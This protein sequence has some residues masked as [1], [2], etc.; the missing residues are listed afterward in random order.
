ME[1]AIIYARVSSKEQESE[2][3]SIPAQIKLLKEYA[4]KHGY[5]IKKEFVEAETAKKAGRMQFTNMLAFAQ[6]NYKIKHL[7]VEKTDRLLRNFY[8]YHLIECLIEAD[9]VSV[10]LVKEGVILSRNSRSNEK[11]MVGVRALM[12]KNSSDNLSEEVTKGMLEKA[13]QGTYPS[14][15]PYGYLNAKENG[16]KVIKIDPETAPYVQRMFELYATE[17]YSLLSLR[18]KILEEGMNY[19][20]GRYFHKSIVERILKNDFYI[21][22]FSWNGKLYE[23]DHKPIVDKELFYK[24]QQIRKNSN[25]YKSRKD[26]FAYT[27]L[28]TCGICGFSISAQVKKKKYIYYHCSGYK[29]NCNQPYVREEVVENAFAS[30]L[31]NLKITDEIQRMLLDG[32]RA[33][34]KDK[35]EFHNAQVS[36]VE[37]QIRVLQH[38]IDQSYM[39]KLDEKI[40][41]DFWLEQNKKWLTEKENLTLQLVLYQKADTSYIE[42]AS[43][44]LELAKNASIQFKDGTI[45]QKRKII[46]ALFSNCSMIDGNLDLELVLPYNMILESSKTGNWCTTLDYFRT[47]AIENFQYQGL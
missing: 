9:G 11:F 33:S 43:T 39:D 1:H 47:F 12:S 18:K 4:A 8:D 46:R 45:E 22:N 14:W 37:K 38:R 19:R 5:V 25:K 26:L 7:L 41:E 20:N 13:Q 29:G 17:Q 23:G 16:R 24:V 6:E 34:M 40:K 36:R 27:N 30:I 42:Q 10:H 35:I 32:L 28:M 31:D 2:G 21:G 15:A 3:Y 44:I